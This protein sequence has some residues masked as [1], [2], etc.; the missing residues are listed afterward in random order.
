MVKVNSLALR[1]QYI[2]AAKNYSSSDKEETYAIN[3]EHGKLLGQPND[4]ANRWQDI[5][6][7]L[8]NV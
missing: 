7:E 1:A 2:R 6:D 5:F 8:F 3:V 4:I